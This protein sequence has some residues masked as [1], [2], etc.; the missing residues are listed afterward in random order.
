[1]SVSGLNIDYNGWLDK[2]NQ[3]PKIA[4]GKI[5]TARMKF[6][7]L[8]ANGLNDTHGINTKISQ[9]IEDY[10]SYEA[11]YLQK[12]SFKSLSKLGKTKMSAVFSMKRNMPNGI[13]VSEITL[14][15]ANITLS[16]VNIVTCDAIGWIADG[17]VYKL[18]ARVSGD[19]IKIYNTSG[20]TITYG[21]GIN[22]EVESYLC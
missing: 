4:S 11:T 17:S 20:Q 16:Q 3:K 12:S 10:L 2:D 5:N 18:S 15:A 22:V 1:M 7:G 9:V 6:G 19:N 21:V 8:N 14:N 13:L